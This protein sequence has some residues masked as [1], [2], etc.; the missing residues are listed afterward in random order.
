MIPSVEITVQGDRQKQAR[1]LWTGQK[2]NKGVPD[3]K[4]LTVLMYRVQLRC[5]E[6]IL[7][8]HDYGSAI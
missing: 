6:D 8:A 5:H 4:L 2:G 7:Q 1:E 3:K